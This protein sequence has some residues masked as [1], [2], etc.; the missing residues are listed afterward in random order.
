M[1]YTDNMGQDC[2]TVFPGVDVISAKKRLRQQHR[3][4]S[5]AIKTTHDRTVGQSS[6]VLSSFRPSGRD[7]SAAGAVTQ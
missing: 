5:H 7:N 3:R 4:G 2:G 6:K 1:Q